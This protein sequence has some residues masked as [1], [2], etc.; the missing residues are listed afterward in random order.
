MRPQTE[1]HPGF[2][3]GKETWTVIWSGLS[4]QDLTVLRAVTDTVCGGTT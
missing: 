4:T 1:V 3:R 2:K